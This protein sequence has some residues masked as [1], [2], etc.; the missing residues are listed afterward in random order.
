MNNVKPFVAPPEMFSLWRA[1]A[2]HGFCV[3]TS[4]DILSA[5]LTFLR[6][7]TS[8]TALLRNSEAYSHLG[9]SIHPKEH[10]F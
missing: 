8:W 9:V 3:A 4:G 1:P 7:S 10:V 6:D 5:F 2:M